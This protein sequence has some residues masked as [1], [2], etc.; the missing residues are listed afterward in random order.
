MAELRERA[1][2]KQLHNFHGEPGD[3][4][5]IKGTRHQAEIVEVIRDITKV[6]WISNSPAFIVVRPQNSTTSIFVKPGQIKR[7]YKRK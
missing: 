5:R 6:E 4:V 1:F 3:M 7:I 2:E